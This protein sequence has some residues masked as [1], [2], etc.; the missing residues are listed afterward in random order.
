MDKAEL[1]TE[2]ELNSFK[3]DDIFAG[4]LRHICTRCNIIYALRNRKNPLI[5]PMCK[6][7]MKVEKEKIE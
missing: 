3:E 5:C 2:R 7:L 1:M 4:Q 6:K